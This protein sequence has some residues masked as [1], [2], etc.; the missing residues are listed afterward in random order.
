M[1]HISS[2]IVINFPALLINMNVSSMP[3]IIKKKQIPH[4]PTLREADV[5]LAL[6]SCHSAASQINSFLAC[7]LDVSVIEIAAP[8]MDGLGL[9]YRRIA[10][11]ASRAQVH[12]GSWSYLEGPH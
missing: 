1:F 6:S 2:K 5:K 7:N 12:H 10:I 8:R 9:G 4:T 3:M 11:A